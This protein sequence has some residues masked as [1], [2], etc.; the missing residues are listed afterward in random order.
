MSLSQSVLI[1]HACSLGPAAWLGHERGLEG[2]L[3]LGGLVDGLVSA[4]DGCS[5][6]VMLRSEAWMRLGSKPTM[7]C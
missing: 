2:P 6:L 1:G 4:T 7:R 3:G 5:L